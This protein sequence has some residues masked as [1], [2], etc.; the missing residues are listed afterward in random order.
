MFF[1]FQPE[2][3]ST[4]EILYDLFNN[5]N[6][7]I[8]HKIATSLLTGIIT[9][10]DNFNNSNT[11][12]KTI[13]ISSELIKLGANQKLIINRV[14]QQIKILDLKL[15]GKI[16]QRL[17][18]DQENNMATTAVFLADLK[19][20]GVNEDALDGFT[21]LL[22]GLTGIDSSLILKEVEDG[23]KGSLRTTKNDVDVSKIAAKYGGGGHK[24]ASGFM[25]QGKIVQDKKGFWKIDKAWNR[26]YV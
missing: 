10:T 22:N 1:S 9:D 5:L 4:C 13:K 7:Q 8:N 19:E 2:T 12:D 15:W 11:S 25:T 16:L 6:Y 24:K 26:G 17:S 23:I 14:Y 20:E 21:A 18:I 3:S